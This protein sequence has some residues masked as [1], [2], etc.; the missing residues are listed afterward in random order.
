LRLDEADLTR[1]EECE[2]VDIVVNLHAAVPAQASDDMVTGEQLYRQYE[3]LR[4]E[5]KFNRP[6]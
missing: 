1:R 2:D 3:V 6:P 4:D 5:C